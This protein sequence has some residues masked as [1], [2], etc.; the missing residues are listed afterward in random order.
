MEILKLHTGNKPLAEDVELGNIARETFGFSGAH[1]ESVANEAAI[2]AM[3]EN[4]RE[5]KQQH[6]Q[7]AIDKVMMGDKLDRRPVQTEMTRI[8][9]HEV[10]HALVSELMREGSVSTL[11]VT[12]RGQALGYMRQT[13]EDDTYLYTREQ[14]ENQIAVMLAGS[15]AEEM[16]LGSR[17]TGSTNDFEQAVQA[18]QQLIRSGLSEL[19]VVSVENVPREISFRVQGTIIREQE[20][21]VRLELAGYREVLE[22]VANMLLEEEKISGDRLRQEIKQR[23]S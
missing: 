17:S 9:V 20:D 6:F 23:A 15:L 12:P 21:R 16:V 19:G 4:R 18:A 5:I 8:A 13:P 22:Q 3:R 1:L 11:T 14:L 7:E 2:L 10:G